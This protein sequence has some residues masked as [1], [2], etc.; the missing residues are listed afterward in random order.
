[1][2][3]LMQKS[4]S[5]CQQTL[6]NDD[7]RTVEHSIPHTLR[8]AT[9]SKKGK[10]QKNRSRRKQNTTGQCA[11]EGG[12]KLSVSEM[13]KLEKSE[14]QA[15]SEDDENWETVKPAKINETSESLDQPK[16]NVEIILEAEQAWKRKRKGKD[17]QEMIRLKINRVRK[18]IQ[19]VF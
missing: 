4:E 9:P 18:A 5:A 2:L 19:L 13:L 11:S 12:S 6:P 3:I 8:E 7:T 1:M 16:K 14:E 10:Q 17:L 15:S